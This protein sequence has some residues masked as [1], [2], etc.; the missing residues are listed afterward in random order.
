MAS[1]KEVKTRIGSV[2]STR[3]ITMAR[4]M[5]SSA[6]LHHWQGIL[7]NALSYN[8][9]LAEI[10]SHVLNNMDDVD[11]PFTQHHADGPVAVVIMSSNTGMAGAFNAKMIKELGTISSLYPGEKILYFPVGRKI[12]EAIVK[13]GL[14]VEG[15]YDHLS[16]K[17]TYEEAS[18]LLSRL[19][20]LFCTHKLKQLDIIYYHFKNRVTQE[21]R[22][23]TL[24]PYTF[25]KP[26]TAVA[27]TGGPVIQPDY[28]F[29][30]SRKQLLEEMLPKA[31]NS[32]F[33]TMVVDNHTAE[34][35]ARMIA[36]QLATEN[37]DELLDELRMTYNKLRQQNITSELLDIIGSSFA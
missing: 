18:E 7:N 1:L 19:S 28:I 17:P 33:Y 3:K 32:E 15:N 20:D 21:I 31:L 34:S 35:A 22:H 36:M 37:A 10:V 14:K 27:V 24:L 5:V 26:Q 29:E 11:F 13:S 8:A 25:E 16:E 9:A 12:R 23:K 2:G 6:Q 4:Q 30:P